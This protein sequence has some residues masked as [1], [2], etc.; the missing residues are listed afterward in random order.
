[1]SGER[2]LF[3]TNAVIALLHGH[4]QLARIAEESDW[5]AISVV[6]DIEYR[7]V[8]RPGA[9][10]PESFAALR[11]RFTEI[12]AVES[13]DVRLVEEII[14]IRRDIRL[15]LPDA[16]VAATAIVRRAKLVT[17]D[18][19]FRPVTG[20]EVISFLTRST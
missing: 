11:Q 1:M 10:D 19:D 4:S 9:E 3:D 18:R 13:K 5:F 14:R 7:S 12:V 15:K 20:L 16:I 2:V 17:A 6:T 8:S